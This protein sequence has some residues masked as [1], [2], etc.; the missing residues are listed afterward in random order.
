MIVI[1][2]SSVT[3]AIL[4]LA[5]G[6]RRFTAAESRSSS[7]GITSPLLRG[8]TLLHPHKSSSSSSSS[9]TSS[10]SYKGCLGYS[11]SELSRLSWNLQGYQRTGTNSKPSCSWLHSGSS[12]ISQGD[13]SSGE[14]DY[15]DDNDS[16]NNINDNFQDDECNDDANE[17]NY[18][19]QDESAN[20]GNGGNGDDDGSNQVYGNAIDD[21]EVIVS[22]ED[23][24]HGNSNYDPMEDFNI[25]LVR[26][27]LSVPMTR[28]FDRSVTHDFLNILFTLHIL[29]VRYLREFVALGPWAFVW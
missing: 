24:S 8:R 27:T 22:N 7:H 9:S 19:Q 23:V 5:R 12:S 13:S 6:T 2:S 29:T 16:G 18:G 21:E 15:D 17:D 25:Q 26:V 1:P 3:V 28:F 11:N 4:L 20:D 14:S 10:S